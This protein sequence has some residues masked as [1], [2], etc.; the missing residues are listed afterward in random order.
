MRRLH[1]ALFFATALVVGG[2]FLNRWRLNLLHAHKRQKREVHRWED[3]GG[4]IPEV[5]GL[6]TENQNPGAAGT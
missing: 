6:N 4:F 1:S 2:S 3:D 5:S